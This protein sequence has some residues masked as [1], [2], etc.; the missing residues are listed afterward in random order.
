MTPVER[1]G[2]RRRRRPVAG[3]GGRPGE[4]H[5]DFVSRHGRRQGR[6][7]PELVAELS[8][9]RDAVAVQVRRQR[10]ILGRRPE[11]P[12][13]VD[14]AVAVNVRVPG[15]V[16]AGVGRRRLQRRRGPADAVA[17]GRVARGARVPVGGL[18][19]VGAARATPDQPADTVHPRC[20]PRGVAGADLPG[21]VPG[22]PADQFLP[23]ETLHPADAQQPHRAPR[24]VAGDDGAAGSIEPHQAAGLERPRTRGPPRS[25]RARRRCCARPA[26]RRCSTPRRG[27]RR[28]WRRRR[29]SRCA[30]PDRRRPYPSRRFPA[31]GPWRSCRGWRLCCAR[32]ARPRRRLRT[33][34]RRRP[35]H[36][37]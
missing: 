6:R 31:C 35:R 19:D 26:R 27:P 37:G 14:G 20:A 21:V 36:G 13:I 34:R 29:R 1:V 4:V 30:R 9:G 33:R 5:A 22:Q 18:N 10:R 15:R 32:R 16:D 23:L 3:V 25:C 17:T 24:S 11:F 12:R 8:P 28:S 7:L 2:D